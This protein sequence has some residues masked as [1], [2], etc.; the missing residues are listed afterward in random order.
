MNVLRGESTSWRR[1]VRVM[2]LS[3]AAALATAGIAQADAG[4]ERGPSGGR[5]CSLTATETTVIIRAKNMTCGRASRVMQ[6]YDGSISSSFKAGG[7]SCHQ[8]DGVSVG[9][10]WKCVNDGKL[11]RFSF[12]D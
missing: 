3:A 9:G 11:F 4:T 6:R 1:K 8:T 7:F 2:T 10:T 12:A 5:D